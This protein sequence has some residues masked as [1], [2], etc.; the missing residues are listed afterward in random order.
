MPGA[1]GLLSHAGHAFERPEFSFEACDMVF[2]Y[3]ELT[4]LGVLCLLHPADHD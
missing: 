1:L 3:R 4:M 2:A